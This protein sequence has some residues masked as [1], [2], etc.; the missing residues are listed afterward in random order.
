[1]RDAKKLTTVAKKIRLLILDIDGVMTDGKLYFS[2]TGDCMKT[3]HAQD[4]LGLKMMMASGIQIAIISG[5]NSE[6]VKKRAED[7]GITTVY[8]GQIKKRDALEQCQRELAIP[9]A[10]IAYMGDD[11]IDIPAM[12]EVALKLAPANA[13]TE[14]KKIAHYVTKRS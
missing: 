12:R 10:Q 3:F 4:G 14:V 13:V 2:A 8:Q 1:M 9:F 7:L 6:I 5:R 11:I